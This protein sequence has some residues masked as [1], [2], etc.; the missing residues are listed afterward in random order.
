M[1]SSAAGEDAAGESFAG[2]HDS[3][4]FVRGR[5]QILEAI[6]KVW[7]SAYN[8]RALAYRRA[9]GISLDGIAVAVVVQT[10]IEARTSGVMF[11]ANPTSG[12]V[13]E[14][15]ISSLWGAGEGLVSAG[16]D[17]DTYVDRQGDLG[18]HGNDRVEN[19]AARPRP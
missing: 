2:L 6:R 9:K 17:A 15:V 12:S 18:D 3:F 7:A 4:L 19:R 13:H 5:E 14:I 8:E 16:F 10:M 11:T 1:R